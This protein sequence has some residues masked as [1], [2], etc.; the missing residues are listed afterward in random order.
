MTLVWNQLLDE[1]PRRTD[2]R[3]SKLNVLAGHET[4]TGN[5]NDLTRGVVRPVGCNRCIHEQKIAKRTQHLKISW[6]RPQ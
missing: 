1:S 2:V 4:G 6:E 5:L 3:N